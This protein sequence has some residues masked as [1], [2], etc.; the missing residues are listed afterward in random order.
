MEPSVVGTFIP[1]KSVLWFQLSNLI[2]FQDQESFFARYKLPKHV[3][4]DKRRQNQR[5]FQPP[6]LN[7]QSAKHQIQASKRYSRVTQ[8]QWKQIL[9]ETWYSKQQENRKTRKW[10]IKRDRNTPLSSVIET[11]TDSQSITHKQIP[12][13]MVDVDTVEENSIQHWSSSVSS[14]SSSSSIISDCEQCLQKTFVAIHLSV[15]SEDYF[16]T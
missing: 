9:R 6:K 11:F 16:N 12:M 8:K 10:S 14:S 2:F 1:F 4:D 5:N 3:T 7:R 13:V 15:S